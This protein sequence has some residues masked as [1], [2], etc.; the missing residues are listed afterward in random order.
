LN[1][2]TAGQERFR[3]ICQAYYRSANAI[4]IVYDISNQP[5]F[6]CLPTW[7]RELKKHI[8]DDVI[9]VL[10]G[11]K[12]DL[13]E[14]REIPY[15]IGE[16]FAQ[17]HNMKFVETSA[18]NSGNVEKI[19]KEIA[20]TLTRQENELFALKKD[21]SV[22]KNLNNPLSNQINVQPKCFGCYT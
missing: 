3:T 15:H 6:D 14:S 13:N 2:D 21:D 5:S 4:I 7:L 20:E 11:N 22:S 17:R 9:T 8:N 10:V 18:K 1:R 16:S 12:N 19:F